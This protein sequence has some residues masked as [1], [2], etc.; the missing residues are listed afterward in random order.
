MSRL[1]A[2]AV[3]LLTLAACSGN[4]DTDGRIASSP[5]T[6]GVGEQRILVAVTDRPTGG[7]VATPDIT[8]V[9]ILRDDIGSP[10]GE[11]E[12]EFV[13]TIPDVHGLYAFQVDIPGPATYQLTIDAGSLGELGPIGFVAAED[14]IQVTVGDQAPQSDTRTLEDAGM[15]ELTSDPTPEEFFYQMSVAEAVS[16]GPSVIVF[17]T[18]EWCTSR[19]CGPML[20]QVGAIAPDYPSLNFVHVEVY[21]NIQVPDPNDLV[22]VPAVEE[23]GLPTEPWLYVIDDAGTVTAAFEGAVSD[24]E[25]QTALDA[26]AG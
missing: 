2:A 22:L 25:L 17:A 12:G 3:C 8:P 21:E 9:A 26:V 14:P 18:P 24:D 1:L 4:A 6:I 20:D 16:S 15:D 19:A 10:L 7:L 13:W 23:W 5:G 11:Y